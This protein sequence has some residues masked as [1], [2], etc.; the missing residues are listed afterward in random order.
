MRAG[1]SQVCITPSVGLD[2]GGYVERQQPSIGVHDDLCVRGLFLEEQDEKL[3]WLHCDLIGLSSVFA[4]SLKD[5]F[6]DVY[7]LSARQVVISATHT[8]SGPA[9]IHLRHCG[10]LDDIYMAQLRQR[11]LD[12]ARA[13]MADLEPVSLYFAEG[14]CHLAK[15]RRSGSNYRHVDNRLPVLAFQKEDGSYLALLA[16]YA[17]HNVA[18]SYENRLLS[19]DVAGIAAARARL[20]L[21]GKPITLLTNGGS[22]NTVPP[23]VSPDPNIMLAFGNR[24]GD[25]VAHIARKSKLHSLQIL[26]SKIEDI[27]LPLTLLSRQEVL[28]EY[29]QEAARYKGKSPWLRAITDWKDDTLELLQGDPPSSTTTVLQVIRIGPLAFTAIGAEVFSRLGDELRAVNG[30]G[31]Y[32]VGYTNGNIGYLP[33][34]EAYLEGGYEVETAYKFYANFM[35][36]VGGYE[37]VR[38]RAILL[39]RTMRGDERQ[40]QDFSRSIMGT[41]P[42]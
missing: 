30:P 17:M 3:L 41:Y 5:K 6:R 37:Q 35:V 34:R 27:D 14:H 28:I 19:A 12:A 25:I 1:A 38:E 4:K 39:L 10:K 8:H 29:R 11:M 23:N 21:P 40:P 32:V 24:I 31:N 16:N 13:A 20:S 9:T 36:S 7:G 42:R 26:S 22:A 2:L 15:D 18:L 33:S